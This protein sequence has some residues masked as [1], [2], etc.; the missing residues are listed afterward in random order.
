MKLFPALSTPVVLDNKK[1]AEAV[2]I[3]E[4][5]GDL[6]TFAERPRSFNDVAWLFGINIFKKLIKLYCCPSRC[7]WVFFTTMIAIFPS[8]NTQ[9]KA[10]IAAS[11]LK[12]FERV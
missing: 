8:F 10:K 12:T 3:G 4:G 6:I 11:Q 5:G 2:G 9:N 7:F 1:T